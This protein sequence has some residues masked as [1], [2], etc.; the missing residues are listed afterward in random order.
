M[1]SGVARA[2]EPGC[3]ADHALILEGR[4]GAGKST[5]C[6]HTG[7]EGRM[8][9][10]RNCRSWIEGQRPGS[11]GKVDHR[12]SANCP[13][14]A[15]PPSS[16]SKRFIAR[17][18]DHYR[19]SYGR[20]SQDFP[21]GCIFIGVDQRDRVSSRHDRQSALVAGHGRRHQARR[22][23]PRCRPQLWAEA[24]AAYKAGEEWWLDVDG[25]ARAAEQQEQ[26]AEI[27]PWEELVL[28]A[29]VAIHEQRAGHELR[30]PRH[31]AHRHSQGE[32]WRP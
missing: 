11:A 30:P 17:S 5:A 28:N 23:A 20:N 18:S 22:A 26:R 14:W 7:T 2:F 25:E 16:A 1:I 21:R 10:G 19:P 3:K 8:V 12:A 24:V 29:A 15:S 27:D 31:S 32:A 6:S 13:Q 9:H 4:Q